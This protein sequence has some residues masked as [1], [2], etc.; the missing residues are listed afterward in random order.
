MP[1]LV[2]HAARVPVV[3]ALLTSGAYA[4]DFRAIGDIRRGLFPPLLLDS[5]SVQGAL[6]AG[7]G[8]FHD[9]FGP[10]QAS[11]H[12][13]M[14]SLADI[15]G[16]RAHAFA[17]IIRP[18]DAPVPFGGEYNAG[19]YAIADFTDFF[20]PGTPGTTVPGSVRLHVHG[21]LA[22]GTSAGTDGRHLSVNTSVQLTINA[23]GASDGGFITHNVDNGTPNPPIESGLLVGFDGDDTVV[24]RIFN[25]PV[26]EPFNLSLILSAV[27][28]LNYNSNE[29]TFSMQGNVD[30]GSTV[31]FATDG[32]AFLLPDG[33]TINSA[34]AGIVDGFYVVP[35]PGGA[36][37]LGLGALGAARRRR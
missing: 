14:N 31:T 15:G 32:P 27:T 16:L 34:S 23:P 17:S 33:F 29:P 11:W 36:V 2:P 18:S 24:T 6:G 3:L 7:G 8:I 9:E 22:E 12:A 37:L 5:Y 10:G 21:S 30:F 26:N 28:N 4:T 19:G 20:I 35:A 25:L 1:H 13:N